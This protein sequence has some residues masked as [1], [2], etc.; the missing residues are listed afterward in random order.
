[1]NRLFP[2]LAKEHTKLYGL[3]IL[4]RLAEGWLHFSH[5]LCFIF[6]FFKATSYKRDEKTNNKT[7]IAEWFTSRVSASGL[8][9]VLYEQLSSDE[10]KR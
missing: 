9:C 3:P 5:F 8:T 6:V 1:M 2:N 7:Q 10:V 4:K